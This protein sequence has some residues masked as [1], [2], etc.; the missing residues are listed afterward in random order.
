MWSDCKV[1]FELFTPKLRVN[2]L[3]ATSCQS[4]K[5]C[6]VIRSSVIN[7]STLSFEPGTAYQYS[8][9]NYHLAAMMIKN[10]TGKSYAMAINELVFELKEIALGV[11]KLNRSRSQLE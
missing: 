2:K 5:L 9:L 1:F 6:G 8:N 7:S 4:K 3:P 11:D 10:V